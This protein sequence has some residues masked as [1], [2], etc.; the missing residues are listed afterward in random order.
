MINND[1]ESS[2]FQR[3]ERGKF[4]LFEVRDVTLLELSTLIYKLRV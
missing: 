4:E 1:C 2:L 3:I